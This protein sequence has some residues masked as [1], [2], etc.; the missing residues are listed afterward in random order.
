MFH[1]FP[2]YTWTPEII[3]ELK[4]INF[5]ERLNQTVF[6]FVC[7]WR[8]N[9]RYIHIRLP[10][11]VNYILKLIKWIAVLVSRMG[12]AGNSCNI[13]NKWYLFV[14]LLM[15]LLVIFLTTLAEA[16]QRWLR[17]TKIIKI[18]RS[19]QRRNGKKSNEGKRKKNQ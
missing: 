3:V 4:L 11:D 15:L 12:F 17:K 2:N 5:L 10:Y 16:S 6:M 1:T 9:S 13:S 14:N 7:L 8:P 18:I 19:E